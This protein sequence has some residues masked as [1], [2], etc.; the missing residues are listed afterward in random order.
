MLAAAD[1]ELVEIPYDGPTPEKIRFASGSHQLL[2]MERGTAEGRFAAN[3]PYGLDSALARAGAV[4]VSD[5]G[6]GVTSVASVRRGLAGVAG[7]VPVVWDPHS[8][9]ATPVPGATLVCPNRQE[10][11]GF[12]A[13]HGANL[14]GASEAPHEAVA[15]EARLLRGTWRAHAVAVT[16]GEHG[17]V[18]A[19]GDHDT[20][21]V[22]APSA[23]H[24]DSC[25]AGDRFAATATSA[26]SGGA[27][28]RQAVADAVARASQYVS[29]GGPAAVKRATSTLEAT[30]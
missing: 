13:R 17:A 29:A 18:L 25:G 14:N 3:Q 12:C 24:G 16:M 28:A 20:T 7:Q 22:P 23:H 21:V 11:S 2:R 10:A 27:S 26:F 4:L 19:D 1:V 15:A 30:S 5:Y 9:G 8:R 6:R